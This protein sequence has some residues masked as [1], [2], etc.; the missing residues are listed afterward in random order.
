MFDFQ[1]VSLLLDYVSV[2]VGEISEAR[3]LGVHF[4]NAFQDSL[5]ASELFV[6]CVNLVFFLFVVVALYFS[7]RLH[8][9]THHVVDQAL[10]ADPLLPL[11]GL[12]CLSVVYGIEVGPVGLIYFLLG[13]GR[14]E[15]VVLLAFLLSLHELFK[16]LERNKL[17]RL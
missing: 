12:L 13:L 1:F 4:L 14:L 9:L 15:E 11:L 16:S 10:V 6:V 3:L 17:V 7:D 8:F 2:S 5:L